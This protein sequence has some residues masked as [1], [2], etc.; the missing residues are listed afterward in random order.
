MPYS[1]EPIFGSINNLLMGVLRGY[2]AGQ[3]IHIGTT[4]SEGILDEGRPIIVARRNRRASDMASTKDD[5][6]TRSLVV[7]VETLTYGAD[8]DELG[9]QL[10]EA[11]ARALTQAQRSQIVIPDGGSLSEI[12]NNTDPSRASD[13]ATSTGVVQY[14]SLPK[15]W[16][17]YESLW[18]LVVRPPVQ[19]TVTNPFIRP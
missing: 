14:A 1:D 4:L 2:F 3:D 8:A 7:G 15:G 9:E 6:F 19:G 12:R 11:C 17:R 10:Q 13:W 18:Q 5:R 16:I